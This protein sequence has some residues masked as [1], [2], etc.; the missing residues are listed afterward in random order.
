MW[1]GQCW[2]RS[3]M[4]GDSCE[5]GKLTHIV[6]EMW[7][8]AEGRPS[9]NYPI[10]STEQRR[11]MGW[12][13]ATAK[14]QAKADSSSYFMGNGSALMFSSPLNTLIR[15]SIFPGV[16]ATRLPLKTLAKTKWIFFCQ[17]EHSDTAMTVGRNSNNIGV[18]QRRGMCFYFRNHYLVPLWKNKPYL[19]YSPKTTEI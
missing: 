4:S 10:C 6:I 9:P 7:S 16:W 2:R 17:T 15:A 3:G 8:D 1:H 12:L 13:K 5:W 19:H 11:D 14:V 18:G